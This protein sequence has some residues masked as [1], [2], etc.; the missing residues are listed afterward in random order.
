MQTR[1][2][3]R[4]QQL[5]ALLE[6]RIAILEFAMGTIIQRFNLGEAQYRVGIS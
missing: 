1:P 3:T 5:P 4:A 2:Y 6:K